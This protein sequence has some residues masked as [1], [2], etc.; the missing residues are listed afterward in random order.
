MSANS[1]NKNLFDVEYSGHVCKRLYIYGNRICQ[2][3]AFTDNNIKLK[4][5]SPV[6]FGQLSSIKQVRNDNWEL[7]GQ[8]KGMGGFLPF[9]WVAE[10]NSKSKP[11]LKL[12]TV[13][14]FYSLFW[15]LFLI[16]QW[17]WEAIENLFASTNIIY[18]NGYSFILLFLRWRQAINLP[19]WTSP[20]TFTK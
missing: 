3:F 15:I 18:W 1:I 11:N 7:M 19:Y 2:L 13:P 6:N 14:W 5:I 10:Q 20:F 9:P 12:N 8:V 17:R 16:I 4:Q